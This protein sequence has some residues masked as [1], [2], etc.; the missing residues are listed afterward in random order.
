MTSREKLYFVV[1]ANMFNTPF[2]IHHK[3][4]LKGSW[5]GRE[6]TAEAPGQ[7][8]KDVDFTKSK[9]KIAVGH[10]RAEQLKAQIKQDSKFL[11]DC[12][13]IDYSLLVGI[14]EDAACSSADDDPDFFKEVS[15]RRDASRLSSEPFGENVAP[16]HQRDRGGMRSAD[17]DSLYLLGIIDILTEYDSRKRIEH[18]VKGL[19]YEKEG[20]SCC[21]P[22]LYA[23]RFDDFMQQAFV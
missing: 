12:N 18:N 4:D 1:M 17:G 22:S 2:P 23:S 16:L 10:T 7:C 6:T 14:H 3:Y 8:L 21:P 15:P 11:S 5:V 13:I 9:M 20:V 19:L